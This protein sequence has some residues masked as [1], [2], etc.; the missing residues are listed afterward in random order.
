[1][2][3]FPSDLPAPL[4]AGYGLTP[5]EQTIRTDMDVGAARVRR[6]STARLDTVRVSWSLSDAQAQAFRTWFD[7]SAEAAGGASWFDVTLRLATGGAVAVEAR[8]MGAPGF[9][10]RGP[11]RWRVSAEL[12]VRDA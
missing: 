9:E 10:F 12:E 11:D 5:R 4:A 6:R 1:M 3:A 8:F 7:S 2:A